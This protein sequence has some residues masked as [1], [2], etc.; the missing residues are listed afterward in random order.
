[1]EAGRDP[2]VL[3]SRALARRPDD[4]ALRVLAGVN[5]LGGGRISEAMSHCNLQLRLKLPTGEWAEDMEIL[6]LVTLSLSGQVELAAHLVQKRRGGRFGFR[7]GF[8]SAVSTGRRIAETELGKVLVAWK[9][10]YGP[11]SANAKRQPVGT[12]PSRGTAHPK[13]PRPK[14][15]SRASAES[16]ASPAS[17]P[18]PRPEPQ[19][20]V[21]AKARAAELCPLAEKLEDVSLARGPIERPDASVDEPTVCELRRELVEL[22]LLREFGELLCLSQ[23][24]GV[25]AF[26]YQVETVKRVL[27][28]MRGR[29]LL[30]DEVGL[31]K[32]IEAGMAL[33][34]Y[35]VRGMVS[36]VLVLVPAPLVTQW[37]TEL[38]S[39]FGL[40]FATTHELEPRT[41][42]AAFW[43]LPRIIASIATAR[44]EEHAALLAGQS[45]DMVIV[46]EA[47]RLRNRTTAGYRLVD[48]LKRKFLLLLSATPVQNDLIELY[49][50]LTLLK[51]GIF[52]TEKSFKNRHVDARSERVPKD[53]ASLRSLMREVM[54]RNTRAVVGM[55]LPPRQVMTIRPDA[56]ASEAEAYAALDVALRASSDPRRR[57][58]LAAILSAAGSCPAA[59]R[60]ALRNAS[61]P[62]EE[63]RRLY[64]E[65]E[66]S[67][68]ERALLELLDTN[69]GERKLVF[70]Q[71]R[72]TQRALVDRI[73]ARG[74]RCA[75]YEGSMS[76]AAK[77]AAIEAIARHEL[78]VLVMT[79]SGGEGH[80]LQFANTLIN[81]DLP[82]NPM[83]VEQRI[84]R[85]HRI[86]QTRE[87]FV[88]NLATRNTVEDHLLRVLDEKLAMFELV[89]GEIGDVLGELD[90]EK[91][92][93]TMVFD[94]W[95]ASSDAPERRFEELERKLLDAKKRSADATE[96]D[97][98]VFGD[99][100]NV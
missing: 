49:N 69:P 89:V 71:H 65:I 44:R 1:M 39:K 99:E 7:S 98:A 52:E 48:G 75:A 87:V 34:E 81:F 14:A 73:S 61:E 2:G 28:D 76:A 43:A 31:G 83:R 8:I 11:A 54:V 82:W 25:E 53:A 26:E 62:F 92:F 93:A 80:N 13:P 42:P 33:K 20:L 60:E 3:L 36:R 68:K 40:T 18:K 59:A 38:E 91:D 56:H 88:F 12:S 74:I 24:T 4:Y 47:H 9:R 96:L 23:L 35:C 57:M 63:A 16:K 5:A 45:Y 79:D 32:T 94:A 84:G 27:K 29:A 17:T 77:D 100:L 10:K 67:A 90:D 6:Y 64:A 50:L 66:E 97:K 22:L 37:K 72:A 30:A 55:R 46:D 85:I 70:T 86:G 78:D 51:P 41:N 58:S 21:T 19:S 15:R 95:L